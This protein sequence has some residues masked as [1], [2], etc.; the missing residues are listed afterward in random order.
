MPSTTTECGQCHTHI[1]ES[2]SISLEQRIPCP[3]CGSL[4]RHVKV[5]LEDS[6]T[7]H[8]DLGAKARHP[9]DKKPFLE[10]KTGDDFHRESGTW[11]KR[12]MVV[13]RENDRYLKIVI[14]P[15]TN[16][17]VYRN[18]EPLSE[19]QGRGSAKGKRTDK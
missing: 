6:I 4:S 18:E 2:P 1:N 17:E 3:Q 19:H 7:V 9:G 13:D 10:Q 12:T 15:A 14:D 11:R 8:A 5:T 16:K